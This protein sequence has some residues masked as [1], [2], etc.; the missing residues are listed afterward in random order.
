M[1]T[2]INILI[3]DDSADDVEFTMTALRNTKLANDISVVNDGVEALQY[4]R[5]E[6][7]F[8]NAKEPSLV[9]LDLNMPRKDGREVLQEM[10]GD[11]RLKHIPVV[12]LTTSQAE[13]D[14]IKSYDLHA[15]C[16]ISKPIDLMELSKVVQAIDNFW[17]G[18]VKLPPKQWKS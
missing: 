13:E 10:K 8:E 6:A 5:K 15:N 17:F 1:T 2:L 14:I 16:Y 11:E 4:L 7:P 3:V 18:V 9:L 12:I